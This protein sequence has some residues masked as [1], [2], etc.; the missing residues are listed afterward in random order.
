[1]TPIRTL[2]ALTSALLAVVIAAAGQPVR[3]IPRPRRS[4]ESRH[5]HTRTRLLPDR[6]DW[7]TRSRQSRHGSGSRQ[8]SRPLRGREREPGAERPRRRS[9]HDIRAREPFD[10]P[11]GPVKERGAANGLIVRHGYVVA[12]WG[13]TSR[14]DMTFS[15]TKT[16][17]ST[18]VGLAWQKGLIRNSPT[19]RA[20]TCPR[21][22]TS[23]PQCHHHVG[24]S[25]AA[26][27]AMAGHAVG[28]PDWADRPEAQRRRLAEPESSRHGHALQCNNDT[29]VNLLALWRSTCGDGRS[30]PSSA[31]R[32]WS[33]LAP[34]RRGAGMG[35]RTPGSTRRAT[36]PVRD[37]RRTL[38]AAHVHLCPRHGTLRLSLPEKTRWKDRRSC[39]RSGSH[40]TYGGT[41]ER[42]LRVMNWFLN[43]RPEGAPGSTRSSVTFRATP[44]HHL[45]R[46]DNDL[47]AVTALGFGRPR[48]ERLPRKV[49][50]RSRRADPEK[51]R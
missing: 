7:Q 49:V 20:T 40:G 38:G 26:G 45:Y 41:G 19:W 8:R 9:G 23:R 36:M 28:K 42:R 50:E 34:R 32:S 29:R 1:M 25:A 15:V 18:V 14:V 12:E 3:R 37:W 6:F 51:E 5:R 44:E 13:D 31:R 48:P 4:R 35:T 27:R 2:R 10:T 22:G 21:P 17:L 33:R 47:V 46:L 11:I 30:R 43:P 16:F 39:P 24:T